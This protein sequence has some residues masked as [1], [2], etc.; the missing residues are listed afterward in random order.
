MPPLACCL[1][2]GVWGPTSS[3]DA[4]LPGVA[5]LESPLKVPSC[6][7]CLAPWMPLA[8]SNPL[9][10]AQDALSRMKYGFGGHLE[11]SSLEPHLSL[12]LKVL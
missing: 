10:L 12:Q 4:H 5:D 11:L 9:V 7:R 2:C 3:G 1:T 8:S 6:L